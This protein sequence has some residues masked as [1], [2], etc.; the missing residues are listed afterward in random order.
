[1][2]DVYLYGMV[3][4]TESLLLRGDYPEADS[5]GEIAERHTVTGGETGTCATILAGLGTRL[6][7][8]GN[9]MGRETYGPIAEFYGGLGVDVSA[10]TYDTDYRG[11]TDMVL[12]GG[13]TRTCLG[14]FQQYFSDPA[15]GRWN[16]PER[17]DIENA[18]VAGIDPFF[19]EASA[20]AARYCR[21][22]GRP[23]VTIDCRYDSEI[24]SLSA[25]N[26]VSG[27][28]IRGQY[29][30]ADPE[31]LMR[32]YAARSKGLT[33]FTYGAREILY[34][35]GDGK[36]RRF[37]PYRV[38]V[39][40]TLGAGDSFKAGAVYGLL[41]GMDDAGLVA[42]ASATAAAAVSRY[43]IPKYPPALEMIEDIMAS[44]T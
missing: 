38:E 30:D 28:Y 3:L 21:E 36:I 33:I 24:H 12:I 40:S 20:L 37:V 5:Y 29:P 18:R 17:A 27:E 6:K 44:R 4:L 41:Q 25:V 15:N 7:V 43:P 1:M 13:H 19:S 31:A 34:G 2:Y 11:L 39:A 35:R 42:F 23:Y 14:Q 16:T 26:I 10:L 22:L 9:H 8:D 32:E